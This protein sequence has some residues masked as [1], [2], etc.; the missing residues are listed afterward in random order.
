MG[1]LFSSVIKKVDRRSLKKVRKEIQE[2][3]F[4]RGSHELTS[5]T[6]FLLEVGFCIYDICISIVVMNGFDIG[7]IS[8]VLTSPIFMGYSQYI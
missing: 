5:K 3:T 7:K 8:Q 2:T 4:N 1:Q 6:P